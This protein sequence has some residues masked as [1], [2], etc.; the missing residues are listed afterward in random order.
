MQRVTFSMQVRPGV[1]ASGVRQANIKL[2]VAPD[3]LAATET[4]IA[5][6]LV[7]ERAFCQRQQYCH[8]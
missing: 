1:V 3:R 6:C 2:S 7:S 4:T 8:A 5:A